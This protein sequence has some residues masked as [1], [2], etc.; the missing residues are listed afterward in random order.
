MAT[1]NDTYSR[2]NRLDLMEPSE[3]IIYEAIQEIEKIGADVRLTDA[4]NM[5]SGA[6]ELVSD[7][8]DKKQTEEKYVINKNIKLFKDLKSNS[9]TNSFFEK[10]KVE[11]TFD[12][13]QQYLCFINYKEGDG[14]YGLGTT[15]LEALKNGIEKFNETKRT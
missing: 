1:P 6:K 9:I 15:F 3:K 14:A 8:I 2:R 7:F 11:V 13:S 4:I 12:S 10:N 5:L